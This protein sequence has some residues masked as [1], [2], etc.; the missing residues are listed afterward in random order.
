MNRALLLGAL[1]FLLTA[2][3]AAVQLPTPPTES[4]FAGTSWREGK[5]LVIPEGTYYLTEDSVLRVDELILKGEL[6]TRGHQL[7]I[8][9]KRLVF[10]EGAA[11]RGFDQPALTGLTGGV[12]DPGMA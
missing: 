9:V 1:V 6:V 4:Y 3:V 5:T 12:G 2:V 7:R 10:K 8:D 11:I